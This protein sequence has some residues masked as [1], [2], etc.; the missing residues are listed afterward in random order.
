MLRVALTV[1][2]V[3]LLAGCVPTATDYEV[4]TLILPQGS[5]HEGRGAFLKLG[6]ASCH[7]VSWE[8]EFPAPVSDSRGP[9]L[10]PLLARH[11][12]G[13]VATSILLPSHNISASVEIADGALSPMGDFTEA[14][15]VR[16]LIDVVAF[17]RAAGGETVARSTPEPRPS[18]M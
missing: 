13:G 8:S 9:D 18:G 11:T 17:L 4:A 12:A 5:P 3:L 10:T 6:C 14:M 1:G 16:Q 7:S 2:C 15:T